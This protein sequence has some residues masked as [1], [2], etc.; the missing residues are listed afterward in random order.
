MSESLGPNLVH[1]IPTE[2]EFHSRRVAENFREEIHSSSMKESSDN[3]DDDNDD[4][5]DF[6]T[7]QNRFAFLDE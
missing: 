6:G 5:D 1:F 3:D 7:T 4:D 2:K